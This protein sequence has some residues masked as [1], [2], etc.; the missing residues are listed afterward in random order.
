MKNLVVMNNNNNKGDVKMNT[1][2][3]TVIS[4]TKKLEQNICCNKKKRAM[5]QIIRNGK[6]IGNC[7][8]FGITVTLRN[9]D[10]KKRL[11]F[12]VDARI[13]QSSLL[14]R[15]TK[16]DKILISGTG[17]VKE[18]LGTLKICALK[19]GDS[20]KSDLE[21]MKV[22]FNLLKGNSEKG[23]FLIHNSKTGVAKFSTCLVEELKE[24]EC[25]YKYAFITTTPSSLG[26]SGIT[27]TAIKKYINS[28]GKVTEDVGF[29]NSRVE[30]LESASGDFNSN[31][32][33]GDNFKTFESR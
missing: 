19:I 31:F 13:Q 11:H 8:F 30:L 20:V 24:N 25:C 6:Q 9:E 27:L 18:M 32:M 28:N 17:Y 1:K 29:N 33:E 26:K 10:D 12:E 22:V 4:M 7:H 21:V 5:S 15:A 2:N 14:L 3:N 16:M 23:I